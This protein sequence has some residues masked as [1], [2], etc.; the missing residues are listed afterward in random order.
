MLVEYIGF[1]YGVLGGGWGWGAGEGVG[2]LG[3]RGGGGKGRFGGR[4]GMEYKS[5]E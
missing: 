5:R 4:V 2:V 3:G 1:L